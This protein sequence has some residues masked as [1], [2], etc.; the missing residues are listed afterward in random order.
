MQAACQRFQS[1]A[2]SSRPEFKPLLL[3][4]GATFELTVPWL[5][6]ASFF[7]HENATAVRSF[8]ARIMKIRLVSVLAFCLVA[9]AAYAAAPDAATITKSIDAATGDPAKVK[10]YCEMS[11]KMTDVGDDDKKAAAAG[12]EI[13]GY[14]KALG[15]DFEAAW[16]AGQ[17]A[18]ED[19]VD[20]KAFDEAMSKLDAKCGAAP[21][22]P[23]SS[24]A[25]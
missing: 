11:K 2:K 17:E 10:A 3:Q 22:A 24:P 23:A 7:R 5:I 18:K 20:G 16:N 8:E 6:A 12:A 9:P 25:P 21:A 13:D 1:S 4:H 14:F 19:S 15:A